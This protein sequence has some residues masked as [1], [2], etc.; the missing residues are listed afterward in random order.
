MKVLNN[1]RKSLDKI[2]LYLKMVIDPRLLALEYSSHLDENH[3]KCMT[4]KNMISRLKIRRI[5]L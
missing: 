1:I 5:Y 2:T 4:I 3:E